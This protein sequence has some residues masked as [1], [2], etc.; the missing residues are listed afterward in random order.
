MMLARIGGFAHQGTPSRRAAPIAGAHEITPVSRPFMAGTSVALPADM[1]PSTSPSS[2][3]HDDIERLYRDYGAAVSRWAT[4]MA[5]SRSDAEDIAQEVFLVAHRRRSDLPAL[6]NPAAWLFRIV[7]NVARHQWRRR[8]RSRLTVV[9]ELPE[10][11]DAR[12]TPLDQLEQRRLMA[13]LDRALAR[14]RKEDRQLLLRAETPPA[15]GASW[16]GE[17][18][19]INPQTLRVRRHRARVKIASWLRALDCEAL[20]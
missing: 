4:Q 5:G 13:H 15:A 9:G 17:L 10:L 2:S 11:P 3:S 8:K 20:A 7:E 6:R 1:V 16:L 19:G 12:P 14:L 18:V